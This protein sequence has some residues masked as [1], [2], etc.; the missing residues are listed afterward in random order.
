[1]GRC[2]TTEDYPEN[3]GGYQITVY[4]TALSDFPAPSGGTI[5]L[6]ANTRYFIDANSINL[7]TDYLTFSDGTVLE[8]TNAFES[9]I[10]YTGIGAA[11]RGTDVTV[12]INQLTLVTTNI[13]GSVLVF[14][15]A[16][17]TKSFSI[18][19]CVIANS[20][21]VG[22]ISGFNLVLFRVISFAAN[23]D[24]ITFIGNSHL[25]FLDCYFAMSNT[26][27]FIDLPSGTF[28]SVILSRCH[29]DVSLGTTGI[30]IDAATA[31][32]NDDITIQ[33][34][35]I[36]G[37]GTLYTGF[38][39]SN[40]EFNIKGNTG[41][42]NFVAGGSMYWEE[43][44]GTMTLAAADSWK[45]ITGGTSMG[46]GL[47][48]FTH[49]SPNRLTY[50]GTETITVKVNVAL[51]LDY[52]SGS[53]FL[54]EI[55]VAKNGTIVTGSAN[56]L[57]VYASDEPASTNIQLSLATNDYIEVFVKKISGAST[58]IKAGFLNVQVNELS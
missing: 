56:G 43:N 55:G 45:K 44:T 35:V 54:A 37:A 19:E 33:S 13:A 34:C 52:D 32:I 42:P 21:K 28:D 3:G 11:L 14:D 38:S 22:L 7:G 26:G 1:M 50:I 36:V 4:I 17:K 25:F 46:A 31:I 41:L 20:N 9:S 39:E 24:G 48:R 57:S 6:A 58:T 16:A 15:N 10:T 30:D 40:L 27:T 29:M 23:T 53:A 47:K 51:A 2:L 12:A 8:G 18:H 5:T 49:T